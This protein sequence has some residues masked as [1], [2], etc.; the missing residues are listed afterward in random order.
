MMYSKLTIW[1]PASPPSTG[2]KKKKKQKK[3]TWNVWRA[4]RMLPDLAL[5]AS[6]TWHSHSSTWWS[7]HSQW[8]IVASLCWDNPER[9]ANFSWLFVAS[10]WLSKVLSLSSNISSFVKP[11]YPHCPTSHLCASFSALP[12]VQYCHLFTC[13][14]S[15]LNSRVGTI[16]PG[17]NIIKL[18]RLDTFWLT[19]MPLL[20]SAK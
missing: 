11:P 12:I 18:T 7:S 14:T 17:I 5:T 10:V 19:E 20:V 4:Y 16:A 8:L 9:I 6:L 2:F 3:L 13:L 1:V 15:P